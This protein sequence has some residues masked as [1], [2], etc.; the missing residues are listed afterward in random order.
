MVK[1][2]YHFLVNGDWEEDKIEQL[3]EKP[4]KDD[5]ILVDG[6]SYR[7]VDITQSNDGYN[8]FLD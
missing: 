8:V 5:V 4:E 2:E 7:V 1:V 3:D 6:T